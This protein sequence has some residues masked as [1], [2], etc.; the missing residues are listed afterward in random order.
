MERIQPARRIQLSQ[1]QSPNCSNKSLNTCLTHKIV[2]CN[3]CISNL[4]FDCE[5]KIK[6]EEG[7]IQEIFEMIN[8]LVEMIGNELLK[9]GQD[10]V[11]LNG[12]CLFLIYV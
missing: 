10:T 5:V 12:I 2:L 1:C 9:N 8:N 4:H 7:F 6:D 3:E 11:K